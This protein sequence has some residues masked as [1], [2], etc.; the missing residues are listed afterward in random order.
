MDPAERTAAYA[1]IQRQLLDEVIEIPLWQGTF[2]VAA[3][4]NVQGLVVPENFRVYLND[5]T[6]LE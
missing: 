2:Y 6:V 4:T 3:R 5:V 1:D